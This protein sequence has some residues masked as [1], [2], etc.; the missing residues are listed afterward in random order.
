VLR[1]IGDF[2]Q[3]GADRDGWIDRAAGLVRGIPPTR[4]DKLPADE[5]DRLSEACGVGLQL[6]GRVA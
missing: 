2:F 1:V 3:F 5:R 6:L 4:F